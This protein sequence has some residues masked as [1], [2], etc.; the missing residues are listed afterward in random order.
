MFILFAISESFCSSSGFFCY[1][2]VY[3]IVHIFWQP[4][5]YNLYSVLLKK[6]NEILL[7]GVVSYAMY[8]YYG[9]LAFKTEKKKDER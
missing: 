3:W 1:N 8:E 2:N 4:Y 7:I 5:Q 6:K 9:R